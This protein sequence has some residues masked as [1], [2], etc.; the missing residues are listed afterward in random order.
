MICNSCA[1]RDGCDYY[2]KMLLVISMIGGVRMSDI[3]DSREEMFEEDHPCRDCSSWDNCDG[4][5]MQF[6]CTLC[7][8]EGFEHCDDCDPMNI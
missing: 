4:W 6:C 2:K 5:E 7:H 3:E 1:D 8:Y